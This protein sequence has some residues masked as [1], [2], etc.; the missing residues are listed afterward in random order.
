MDL[1]VIGKT[2]IVATNL[3]YEFVKK[4]NFEDYLTDAEKNLLI[5][6]ME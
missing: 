5:W 4:L 2:S 6:N 3:I 1:M